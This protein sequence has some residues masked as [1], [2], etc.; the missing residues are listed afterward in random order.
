MIGY[1][2]LDELG[3]K[4]LDADVLQTAPP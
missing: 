3:W 4:I 2:K 1:S